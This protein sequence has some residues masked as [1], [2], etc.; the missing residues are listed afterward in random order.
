MKTNDPSYVPVGSTKEGND[1]AEESGDDDTKAEES[2]D[3]ESVV[4]NSG[5]QVEVSDPATTPEARSKRWFV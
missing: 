3:K 1:N 4:E 5:E 2:D